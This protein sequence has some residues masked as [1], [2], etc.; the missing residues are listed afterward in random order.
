MKGRP[1]TIAP[2]LATLIWVAAAQ[3]GESGAATGPT[4]EPAT[5]PHKAEI[6]PGFHLVTSG[7]RSAIC[8][9]Q[10]DAWIK[11]VL[12]S[13]APATRPTTMPSD[14]TGLIRQRRQE[15]TGTMMQDLAL[16]DR[17]PVDDFLDNKLLPQLGKI[18]AL[19][20]TIYY[21][22][23]TR[24]QV[25]DALA[26]G[27]SDPRFHYI[28][29]AHDVSYSTVAM[30]TTDKPMDDLLWWVEIRDG[31]N[32]ATQRDA[33]AAAVRY[34]EGGMADHL[35]MYGTNEAEHLFERFVHDNVLEPLKLP[36]REN[37]F[38]FGVA[39][40]FAIKYAA[41]VTGMSRRQWTEGLIGR[42]DELRPFVRLDLINALDP[43]EIR[44]E[45]LDD[46]D[47]ALLPKGALVID[48]WFAAEGDGAL[49][50][51][52]PALHGHTPATPQELID[53]VKK[54]TGYDLTPLMQPDYSL[55]STRPAH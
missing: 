52:L 31:D 7:D 35:S 32:A 41:I 36:A 38:D 53:V 13:V 23:A 12:A 10:D 16:G 17:K 49:A 37:W 42:P 14:I 24:S 40:I 26:A 18:A 9:P 47:R 28:R 11:T 8:R 2:L 27:W 44:P 25:A 45:Y 48:S 54:T 46:Y 22:V 33:L 51:V 30:L 43:A 15:L 20:P 55:P 3:G 19:R 1:L 6:P 5:A 29:F 39:N 4:T 34:F 50:K 21:F